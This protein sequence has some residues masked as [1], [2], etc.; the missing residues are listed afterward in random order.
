MSFWL[1]AVGYWPL[2][3]VNYL[4]VGFWLLELKL[5][6]NSIP[7]VNGNS[8]LS[9]P[10]KKLTESKVQPMPIISYPETSNTTKATHNIPVAP[11]KKASFLSDNFLINK[12]Y[13]I[14][15]IYHPSPISPKSYNGNL[16]IFEQL[17]RYL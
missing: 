13:K 15:P 1:L 11:H 9:N 12:A 2:A 10:P 6:D 8:I 7:R 3:F 17:K 5:R 14:L 16:P 4:A